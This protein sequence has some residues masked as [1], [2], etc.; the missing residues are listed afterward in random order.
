MAKTSSQMT[1]G[2][3][4]CH[5]YV[6]LIWTMG[7]RKAPYVS[8]HTH[9][10]LQRQ[11]ARMYSVCFVCCGNVNFR[12]LVY[13]YLCERVFCPAYYIWVPHAWG[14]QRSQRALD[15][16]GT[17]VMEG[18]WV[19][20]AKPQ[21]SGRRSLLCNPVILILLGL[22][23]GWVSVQR[24]ISSSL[25]GYDGTDLFSV[26]QRPRGRLTWAWG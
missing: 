6:L 3:Q 15:S 4:T 17:G 20:G 25:A 26:L 24:K 10:N 14:D 5:A 23:D 21:A 2:E 1:L 13:F 11:A 12:R 19:L 22:T 7:C 16:L 8:K 9:V 18:C